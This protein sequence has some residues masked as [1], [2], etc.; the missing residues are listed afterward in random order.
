MQQRPISSKTAA[1]MCMCCYNS[2][3][4]C[5]F[6]CAYT[7][8]TQAGG[9]SHLARLADGGA[10][11]SQVAACAADMERHAHHIQPKACCSGQQAGCLLR[12]GTILEPQGHTRLRVISTDAQ[13]AAE[14]RVQRCNLHTRTRAAVAV[15]AIALS[16]GSCITGFSAHTRQLLVV[17]SSFLV[18]SAPPHPL[19]PPGPH[20]RAPCG[21]WLH[22][23]TLPSRRSLYCTVCTTPSL[24]P[25]LTDSITITA[26]RLGGPGKA[27]CKPHLG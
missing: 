21:H 4:F 11:G 19:P 3:R 13:H 27:R 5:T 14:A 9:D 20:R 10:V 7:C 12:V 2:L 22:M 16:Q 8:A 18:V 17:V 26:C 6:L 1:C 25:S 23:H 24:P 15:G